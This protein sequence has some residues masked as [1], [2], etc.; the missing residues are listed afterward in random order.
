MEEKEKT[1]NIP[2]TKGNG[3]DC[4][5]EGNCCPPKKNNM[6]TKIIFAVVLLAAIGIIS[7][8]L[9]NK[10]APATGQEVPCKPGSSCCDTTKVK[11][12]DTTKGSSCCP[13][14]K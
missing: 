13:K 1:S 10:P 4:G 14:S 11:T 3:N 2:D 8:K 5:C 12:C 7:V 6:L 9:F